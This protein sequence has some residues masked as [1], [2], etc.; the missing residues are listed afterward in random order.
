MNSKRVIT[1]L[2]GVTIGLTGFSLLIWQ[3][4]WVVGLALLLALWGNNI[5]R[6]SD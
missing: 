4:G 3:A 2:I 5:E 1:K 6:S